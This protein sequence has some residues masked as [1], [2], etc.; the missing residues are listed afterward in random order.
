[1]TQWNFQRSV[2]S[3]RL[4]CEFATEQGISIGS[5][6]AGTGLGQHQLLE[7]NSTVLA[8]QE[9]RVIAN[10]VATLGDAPAVGIRTGMRYHFT[11][12]GALGFAI[13]SS[14]DMR[15]ALDVA[16]QHF[17]LTFAFTR[18]EVVEDGEDLCVYIH[19]ENLPKDLAQFIVERDVSALITVA[20]DLYDLRPM[21]RRAS[22][23]T[24]A[25]CDVSIYES[26]LS[27]SPEFGC[28]ENCVRFDRSIFGNPLPQANELAHSAAID[29]CR[30]LLELRRGR[31]GF[32]AAVRDQIMVRAG[33]MPTMDEISASLHMTPRTLR[34]RLSVEGVTF[35]ELREEVRMSLADDLLSGPQL[36][37]P[38]IAER[39]GYAEPTSFINAFKRWHGTTPHS[40]RLK[41]RG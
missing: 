38:Q 14:R 34:R 15:S 29:Q 21:T 16:L 4:M 5:L 12:F 33:C 40:Y 35:T 13:V 18:F 7:P 30:Q 19:D 22:F 39:L 36:S 17:H 3:V 20:R 41:S 9:L 32:S 28:S 10:L 2:T 27:T 8:E 24:S 11:A 23:K 6:L 37:I 1:M 26:L 25:P 31:E